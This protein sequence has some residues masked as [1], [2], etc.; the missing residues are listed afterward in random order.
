MPAGQIVGRSWFVS[1]REFDVFERTVA[2]SPCFGEQSGILGEKLSYCRERELAF[3]WRKC[4]VL[5][6]KGEEIVLVWGEE[7]SFGKQTFSFPVGTVSCWR[8][9]H[10]L[11]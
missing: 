3:W 1:G 10:L 9:C 5:G 2:F 6:S 8:Q 4:H 7:R 11:T